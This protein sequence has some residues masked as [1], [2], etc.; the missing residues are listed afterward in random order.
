MTLMRASAIWCVLLIGMLCYQSAVAS[1]ADTLQQL[2]ERIERVKAK[3]T[4]QQSERV[5]SRIDVGTEL[6]LSAYKGNLYLGEVIAITS[7]QGVNV[8]LLSLFSALGFVA[9]EDGSGN[10]SGWFFTSDNTFSLKTQSLLVESKGQRTQLSDREVQIIN[11][12]VFLA[13]YI[14]ATLFDVSLFTNIQDLSLTVKSKQILPIEAQQQR[15]GREVVSFDRNASA[16]LPWR[17]S[18]YQSIGKPVLDAQINTQI[19]EG[20]NRTSYSLLGSQDIAYWQAQYFIAGREGDVIN[21]S[22]LSLNR[23]SKKADALPFGNFTKVSLGDVQSVQVGVDAL[24]NEGRG[25]SFG[26]A[27]LDKR[28]NRQ[29]IV[30]S[31]PVQVGWD[32]ELYRNGLLIGQENNVQSGRYEFENVDLL[33]GE[34]TFELVMY[35]GQGQVSKEVQTYYVEQSAVNEGEGFYAVSITET[36]KSMLG[37][38]TALSGTSSWQVNGRFDYGL[39][40]NFAVYAGLQHRQGMK[41]SASEQYFSTGFNTNINKRL[42]LDVDYSRSEENHR[43]SANTRTRLL[44]QQVGAK[45]ELKEELELDEN[46]TEIKLTA[47]GEWPLFDA[48]K[49]YYRAEYLHLDRANKDITE[50]AS[51]LFSTGNY[52]GSF[53]NQFVWQEMANQAS[54]VSGYLRWQRRVLGVYSRF[55]TWYDIKPFNEMTAVEL[56]L[57]KELSSELDLGVTFYKDFTED[58]Y[59]TELGLSWNHD[60]FRLLTDLQYDNE[61]NWQ[62][63]LSGQVSIGAGETVEQVF[64][65]SKRL[66][67]FGSLMV[68]A[69]I[70]QNNNG[71]LDDGELP[72]EGVTIKALQNFAQGKTDDDG[73]ALL[74]SMVNYKRTDIVVDTDTIPEPF[75]IPANDGFSFTPRPGH[76]EFVEIPFVNSSEVEGVI[77]INEGTERRPAGFTTVSLLDEVG[78]EVA[79][80]QTAYDGYYVFTGL[81]PGTYRTAISDAKRLAVASTQQVEVELSAEGDLL[82]D[83]NLELQQQRLTTQEFAVVGRFKTLTILKVYAAIL[84]KRYRAMFRGGFGYA[85]K[86]GSATYLLVLRDSASQNAANICQNLIPFKVSCTVESLTIYER[87]N[88]AIN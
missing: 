50:Q 43:L 67:Q 58:Y 56:E 26:N 87:E 75:L 2:L 38:K 17:S 54:N 22:R 47:A 74:P 19:T 73:I 48:A 61:D 82:L 29:R 57:S 46:S 65:T 4:I 66:S 77:E 7:D 18:P 85:Q 86:E 28:T 62:V 11:G 71:Y 1:Q 40:E 51:L 31:G 12:E 53:S 63:G 68:H 13:D 76:I 36:G 15:L 8:E 44:G 52:W 42:L 60:K 79:R 9:S 55:T 32:V 78:N 37:D 81:K 10:F 83:V 5:V 33:F 20:Y 70:D 49:I 30:I 25:V 84:A 39:T 72:L 59:K 34:N 64:L 14:V 21:R 45:V 41:N 35:G 27:P 23:A 24:N 69:F 80:T 6:F 88:N 3:L 16:T